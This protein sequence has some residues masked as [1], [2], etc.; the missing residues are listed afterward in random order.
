MV[1]R[2]AVENTS[3]FRKEGM[4]PVRKVA[5]QHIRYC[6]DYDESWKNVKFIY[7]R[8]FQAVTGGGGSPMFQAIT[9][10]KGMYEVAEAFDLGEYYKQVMAARREKRRV[11]H[12]KRGREDGGEGDDDEGAGSDATKQKPNAPT[13]WSCPECGEEFVSRNAFGRHCGETG[14][15]KS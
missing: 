11:M 12:A 6:I 14:H 9:D 15:R 4:L 1:A 3:C 10:A 8:H 5:D 2:G 13:G 7:Q